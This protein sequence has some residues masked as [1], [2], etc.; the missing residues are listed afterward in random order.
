MSTNQSKIITQYST[1]REDG[2]ATIS[3]SSN[4]EFHYTKKHLESF[5]KPDSRVLEVGCATGHYGFY[6]ADK[7]KEYVGVDLVPSQIELFNRKISDSGLKNI[8]CH[9]G[10]ATN[11][12]D[13]TNDSFDV[14][15]CLGP[16]YHLPPEERELVFAECRRVCKTGG[17]VAFAYINKIGVYVG[18]CVY[19]DDYYRETYPNERANEFILARGTDDLKPD[20]FYFTTPEEMD[21]TA[22]KHGLI[23]LRNLGTDF[24]ITMSII[25]NMTDERFEVM[26]PLYEQMTSHESC[27][28]MSNHA[29]LICKK[30]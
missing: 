5:I 20:T 16:M 17:I 26:K 22:G 28:G 10:D 15:L 30:Q 13:I 23:K 24:F 9:I 6:Y 7:C 29:L 19:D 11:L 4:L 8:S 27:T 3:R 1:G 21:D 18:A 12:K 14:V 25:N 2:R